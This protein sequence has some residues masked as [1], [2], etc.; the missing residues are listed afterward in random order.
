VT[1]FFRRKSTEEA[2]ARDRMKD[3]AMIAAK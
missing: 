1:V 3:G 2:L